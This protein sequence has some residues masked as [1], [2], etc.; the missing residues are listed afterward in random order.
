MK[1]Y[2]LAAN[3]LLYQQK[4]FFLF[5]PFEIVQW[6]SFLRLLPFSLFKHIFPLVCSTYTRTQIRNKG[7]KSEREKKRTRQGKN[8]CSFE[9]VSIYFFVI[10]IESYRITD[11]GPSDAQKRTKEEEEEGNPNSC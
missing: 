7:R 10:Y 4:E 2:S 1:A 6:P 5:V 11:D 3:A 9:M 8:A